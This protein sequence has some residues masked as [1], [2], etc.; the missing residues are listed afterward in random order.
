MKADATV[1]H[2]QVASDK[3]N[4]L[5]VAEHHNLPLLFFTQPLSH[6]RA[7]FPFLSSD[8]HFPVLGKSCNLSEQDFHFHLCRLI[9]FLLW[10][11]P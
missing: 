4:P 11:F 9:P 5:A 10:Q 8:I 6:F 3:T 2:G 7:R 1:L